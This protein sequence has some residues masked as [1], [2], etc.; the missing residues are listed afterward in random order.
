MMPIQWPQFAEPLPAHFTVTPQSRRS[1]GISYRM[2]AAFARLPWHCTDTQAKVND[3]GALSTCRIAMFLR[4]GFMNRRSCGC[5][6]LF[7][8]SRK[9]LSSSRLAD[10]VGRTQLY[11][12]AQ[13][14][15][16]IVDAVRGLFA[17]LGKR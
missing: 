4:P 9:L 17:G 1:G 11:S 5:S 14:G 3:T 12:R 2:K 16:T 6:T 10:S 8:D 7:P 15:C 13:Q